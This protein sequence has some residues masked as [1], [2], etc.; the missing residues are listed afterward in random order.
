MTK[1]IHKGFTLIELMVVIVI[2]GI[3]AA[4]AIPS[5]LD[6]A[7]R[8]KVTEGINLIGPI[9]TVISEAYIAGGRMPGT[10]ALA[11]TGF[12]PLLGMNPNPV[13]YAT[14]LVQS[15]VVARR[16]D[17][18]AAILIIYDDTKLGAGVTASTNTL[19][20]AATGGAN[21]IAWSCRGN[22]GATLPD[23][24]KPANCRGGT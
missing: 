21:G 22:T 13:T 8:A 9:K 1:Q 2:I 4:I 15:I 24:Y 14:D 11:H 5:Y 6:N 3:L 19:V 20:F 12:A 10:G 7:N 18:Q 17:D 16:G 23:K